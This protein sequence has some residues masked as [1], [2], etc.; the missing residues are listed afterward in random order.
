MLLC[1]QHKLEVECGSIVPV[2]LTLVWCT[3]IFYGFALP[4]VAHM[5][6]PSSEDSLHP[7]SESLAARKHAQHAGTLV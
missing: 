4:G 6:L 5:G 2:L 1:L 7:H 3:D